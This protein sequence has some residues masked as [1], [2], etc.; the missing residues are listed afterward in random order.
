MCPETLQ[1]FRIP[2]VN[3]HKEFT[4]RMRRTEGFKF[5]V[6]YPDTAESVFQLDEPAPLGEGAGPSAGMVLASAVTNCL[7][8]SLTFCVGKRGAE[9]ADLEAEATTTIDRNEQGR[10]RIRKIRVTL[11]PAVA[12]DGEEALEKCKRVFEE[13]CIVTQSV[14]DGI[15]VE[16]VV[17]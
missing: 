8:A 2:V 9:L 12:E 15:P 16:T 10:L 6:T 17:E 11:R 1:D 13:F 4:V 7:A 5:E 3:A 14:K